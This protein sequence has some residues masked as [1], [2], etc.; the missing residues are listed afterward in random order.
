MW[1]STNG[2]EGIEEVDEAPLMGFDC[3]DVTIEANS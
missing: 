3:L 2:Y 1:R